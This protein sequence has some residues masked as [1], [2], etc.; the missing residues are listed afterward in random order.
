MT[1]P[2]GGKITITEAT[3]AVLKMA[4]AKKPEDRYESATQMVDALAGAAFQST[5]IRTENLGETA[6]IVP[7]GAVGADDS[8]GLV[9]EDVSVAVPEVPS[10][11]L[12]K[13]SLIIALSSV[14]LLVVVAVLVTLNFIRPDDGA[15]ENESPDLP[16]E[17]VKAP[18][19]TS[20]PSVEVISPSAPIQSP[21]APQEELSLADAIK[22]ADAVKARTFGIQA[23]VNQIR[24]LYPDDNIQTKFSNN[25]ELETLADT[26]FRRGDLRDQ[27]FQSEELFKALGLLDEGDDLENITRDVLL[28][29][30]SALFDDQSGY[31]Y[32]LSDSSEIGLREELAY[33]S[34]YMAGLQDQIFD[35]SGIRGRAR[36]SNFD[37]FRAVT[38]FASGDVSQITQGYVD[39]YF[40]GQA[41]EIPDRSQRE[42]VL[43][44]SPKVIRSTVTFPRFEGRTFVAELYASSGN[45]DAVD[46]A[47]NQPPVSTEQVIHPDKYLAGETPVETELPDIRDALG[48][49][50][51]EQS[52]N[53]MGEFLLRTYL[54]EHLEFETAS[55]A[56]EGWGGDRYTLLLGPGGEGVFTLLIDWDT[57]DDA[58]EFFGAYQQYADAMTEGMTVSRIQRDSQQWWVTPNRTTYL[59]SNGSSTLLIIADD[60]SLVRQVIS[61][62]PTP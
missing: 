20:E 61:A 35:V 22:I 52:T 59:Q 47:Y 54:E 15:P 40:G 58:A 45:W 43:K 39:V 36:R 30:V 56:A 57:Q 7:T 21:A 19:P 62:F 34:V 50:W 3:R 12:G 38:A 37:E 41:P 27:V 49:G 2:E 4:T 55:F 18:L 26:F 28:Q 5:T 60:E 32:V 51:S 25:E 53:V 23:N 9:V 48:N 1:F 11:F 14:A 13:R 10:R 6:V 16:L 42:N 33:A 31:L 8:A 17:I 46:A 24:N 29:Q 44:S